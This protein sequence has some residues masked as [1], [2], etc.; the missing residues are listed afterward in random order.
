MSSEINFPPMIAPKETAR[1]VNLRRNSI[2]MPMLNK[3][4]LDAIQQHFD[5]I[6]QSVR[7][8]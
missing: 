7:K 8:N 1:G 6:S 4:D 5:Q 2:S 3:I